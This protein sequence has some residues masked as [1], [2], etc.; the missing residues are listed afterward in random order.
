MIA[1]AEAMRALG[2][3][4]GVAL[5]AQR[6]RALV[7]TISGE[8]GAGK[9]TLVGGVLNALGFMGSARSPTYTLIEPYEIDGRQIF[10]LDLYRL[11][12]PR[13]VE[14]LGLRDLLTDDATL[15]IEWPERGADRIPA[16]DL[17][18]DI[19]YSGE[20]GRAVDVKAR[21]EVGRELLKQL[22]QV[23]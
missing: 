13:E 17:E 19:T 18:L 14:A 1:D 21:G 3:A 10:H 12:D 2:R 23:R 8:L 11:A 6:S 15:L 4:L 16:A 7:V 20:S 5:S 9:T 22:V